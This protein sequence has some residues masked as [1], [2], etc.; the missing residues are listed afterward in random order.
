MSVQVLASGIDTLNWSTACGISEERFALFRRARERAADGG[1]VMEF[2]GHLL[3]VEPHGSGR[4]PVLLRSAEFSV[5]LTDSKHL[6]TALVQ[7]R[8]TFL[9]EGAG[10]AGAFAGSA[11]VVE[12][13]CERSVTAPKASR[14]DVYADVGGWVLTDSDRRGLVTH[15]KLHPVLRAG[16]D[17]YETIQ[18]GKQ[19]GLLV[20]LYRKDIELRGKPGFADLLWGGYAGPVVRAE[21][22]AGGEKLREVGIVTVDD[23]ISCYGELWRYAT[24]KFCRLHVP[25]AGDREG[26]PLDPRWAMLQRLALDTFPR[27]DMA[28]EV[29]AARKQERIA[30]GLLGSL[31]SWAASEGVFDPSDALARL[32]ERYPGLVANRSREF[33][34][35]VARRYARLP[36]T[37]RR[38]HIA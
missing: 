4:Y 25:E 14:L 20:R 13:L 18:A 11:D 17:E 10:P 33:G 12:S 7:L 19:P 9:H 35:E 32:Q 23:A 30:E 24:D 28:S 29:K 15:A 8:S 6:P 1:E 21:A 16:T 38:R 36:R 3:V 26:W 37:V 22:E 5:Q 31:A 34:R 2:G 27:C